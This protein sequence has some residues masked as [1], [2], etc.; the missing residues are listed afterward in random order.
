MQYYNANQNTIARIPKT[1]G[2]ITNRQLSP[3]CLTEHAPV[4]SEGN[5]EFD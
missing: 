1:R 4:S 5:N 2:D 3:F